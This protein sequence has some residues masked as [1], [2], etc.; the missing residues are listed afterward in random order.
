[1]NSY[2]SFDS[3][4]FYRSINYNRILPS[5]VAYSMGAEI[6]ERHITLDKNMKGADH[7]ASLE[8]N[9]MEELIKDMKLIDKMRRSGLLS[10]HLGKVPYKSELI[11]KK[12][13]R[14]D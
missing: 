1:M 6:I 9:E 4:P 8:P 10:T 2:F 14:G 5:I 13:L 7:K 12:K 11:A 3:I